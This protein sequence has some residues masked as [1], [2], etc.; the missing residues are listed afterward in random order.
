MHAWALGL[1]CETPGGFGAAGASRA[2]KGGG[3]GWGPKGGGPKISRFVF[4]FPPPCSLFFS[5]SRRFSRG[6]LVVF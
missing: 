2:P 3:E 6:I 4:P 5:L 1:S